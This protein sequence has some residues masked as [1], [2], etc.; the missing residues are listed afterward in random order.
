M[1]NTLTQ[2]QADVLVRNSKFFDMVEDY[3]YFES[4]IGDNPVSSVTH[5]YFLDDGNVLEV[6]WTRLSIIE[7]MIFDSLVNQKGELIT[8]DAM[9]GFGID[10]ILSLQ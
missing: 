5:R 1:S 3:E 8:E 2:E 9:F 6:Y 4:K 10:K 7:T